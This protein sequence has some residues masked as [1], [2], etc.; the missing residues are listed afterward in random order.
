MSQTVTPPAPALAPGADTG[1]SS[2]D[3]I[4]D[5]NAPTFVGVAAPNA[6]INLYDTDGSLIGT[7]TA[8]T[9]GLYSIIPTMTYT[10]PPQT[11]NGTATNFTAAATLDDGVHR[12]TV[13]AAAPGGSV[14]LAS[15]P[16]V[17]TIDSQPPDAP[18]APVLIAA[19]DT[20]TS[21]LDGITSATT[22]TLTGMSEPGAAVQLSDGMTVLGGTVAAADGSYSIT[23][24]TLDAGD[25]SFTVIATDVAGNASK[26]SGATAVTIDTT[27]PPAPAAPSLT[28]GSDTGVLRTDG[29]TSDTTPVVTGTAEAGATVR[30]LDQGGTLLGQGVA[31]SDGS[32]AIASTPLLAGAHALT[33]TATDPAG[34]AGAASTALNI[35]IDTT[36]GTAT[37]IPVPAAASAGSATF[38]V[39][40]NQPIADTAGIKPDDFSLVTTGT[41]FG[42]VQTV[43]GAGQDFTVVVNGLGGA[44]AIGLAF[45][46]QLGITTVAGNPVALTQSDLHAVSG[47]TA[48]TTVAVS[49]SPTD[50]AGTGENPS[51]SATGRG[52]AFDSTDTTLVPGAAT[53]GFDNI[54]VK[55]LQTG[56]ISI[57]STA[58]DGA[59]DGDSF[60]A[61]LSQNDKVI[62][63][64]S[65]ATNLI[66]DGTT[67][68]QTNI[69]VARLQLADPTSGLSFT[70]V[71]GSLQ[72]VSRGNGESGGETPSPID[73]GPTDHPVLSADGSVVAFT[74]AA[75]LVAGVTAGTDNVYAYN[76]KTGVLTLIST[77]SDGSGGDDESFVTS[78]SGDGSKV[79]F[80]SFADNLS[81]VPPVDADGNEDFRRGYVADTVSGALTVID[82][83]GGFGNLVHDTFYETYDL[84]LSASGT[85]VAY[86]VGNPATVSGIETLEETLAT[87]AVTQVTTPIV[88]NGTGEDDGQVTLSAGGTLAL[89]DENEDGLISSVPYS[90][91]LLTAVGK[92]SPPTLIGTGFQPVLTETGNAAVYDVPTSGDLNTLNVEETTFGITAGIDPIGT[93]DEIDAAA[94]RGIAASGGLLVT[95][96]TNAPVGSPVIV[97]M[98]INPDTGEYS[99][100]VNGTVETPGRWSVTVPSADLAV[101]DGSSYAMRVQVATQSGA[102]FLVARLFTID[103]AAPATPGAPR[104]DAGSDTGLAH[105]G[106]ISGIAAPT[107]TGTTEAGATVTLIDQGGTAPGLVLGE[108]TADANGVWAITSAT[109]TDG[110]HALV[111][112]ATDAAGNISAASAPLALTIDTAAPPAPAAPAVS[113]DS[114]AAEPAAGRITKDTAPTLAGE[115]VA[116]ARVTLYDSDGIAV[117][118]TATADQT[119]HYTITSSTLPD[120]PHK[121]T[122][123]QTDPAGLVSAASTPLDLTVDTLPPLSPVIISLGGPRTANAEH[124]TQVDVN[125]TAEPGS[126][127]D[128]HVDMDS[129]VSGTATVDPEGDYTIDGIV[130]A[131]LHKLTVIA[132]DAAGNASQPSAV[133]P[134]T[135]DGP[136]VPPLG[137]PVGSTVLVGNVSDDEIFGATV[138]EDAN[139]NGVLDPGEVAALTGVTGQYTL[140]G[141]SGPLIATGGKDI[142]SG[143]TL[144]G[145]LTAPAGSAAITPFTTLLDAYIAAGGTTDQGGNDL[146]LEFLG[147]SQ[148]TDVTTLD[149]AA[150]AKAAGAAPETAGSTF[151]AE[152][153]SAGI[154]NAA[155]QIAA[156]IAGAGG[157]AKAAFADVFD[158]YARRLIAETGASL[159]DPA[160]ISALLYAAAAE[161]LPGVTLNAAAVQAATAIIA[162]GETTI[163]DAEQTADGEAGGAVDAG[164]LNVQLEVTVAAGI[165][166][167]AIDA[168]ETEEQSAAATALTQLARDPGLAAAAQAQFTGASLSASL[169]RLTALYDTAIQLAPGDDTGPSAFDHVTT[170]DTPTFIGTT[171][172]GATVT[173]VYNS[174]ALGITGLSPTQVLGT[175]VA[176]S[177]GRFAVTSS[178]L[179]TNT[180]LGTDRFGLEAV[181]SGVNGSLAPVSGS[182][183]PVTPLE[184]YIE[185]EVGPSDLQFS[186]ITSVTDAPGPGSDATHQRVFVNVVVQNI[187]STINVYVDGGTTPVGTA[188]GS[189]SD[190]NGNL[191]IETTPLAL[192]SHLFTITDTLQ[193]GTA[194][195]GDNSRTFVVTADPMSG[196]VAYGNGAIAGAT[197]E[198]SVPVQP[199]AVGAT[200]TGTGQA[201]GYTFPS[202]AKAELR[203]GWDTVTDLQLG[204]NYPPDNDPAGPFVQLDAPAGAS[205]VTALTT[206][207]ADIT[208]RGLNSGL[209]SESLAQA[210]AAIL[211]GLGLSPDLDPLSLNPLAE[212]QAGDT[213]PFLAEARLLDTQAL[214]F[215]A[216]GLDILP[217]LAIDIFNNG[218]LDLDDPAALLAILT[219]VPAHVA[220]PLAQTLATLVAASNADL[221]ARAA[222][223]SGTAALI[224]GTLAAE[225]VAQ[226][227]EGRAIFDAQFA[228]APATA[229]QSVT[230]AYTGAALQALVA[231]KLGQSAQVAAFA[232]TAGTT[233]SAPV[234]HY[235]LQFTQPVSGIG[236][237]AFHLVEGSGLADAF[238]SSV[239]PVLG[240]GGASYDVAVST[241]IGQGTLS[242]GFTGS[243]VLDAGGKPLTSG[244]FEPGQTEAAPFDFA[245]AQGLAAGDFNGDGKLDLVE[246]SNNQPGDGLTVFL[247]NGDGT[248][249]ATGQI[250]LAAQLA[251]AVPAVGD[252]NGDGKLDIVT[253]VAGENDVAVLLGDGDGTFQ[254]PVRTATGNDP[255]ALA[256]G[257]LDGDG[258]ADVV[259]LNGDGTISVLLGQG[260][261]TFLAAPSLASGAFRPAQGFFGSI[262]LADLNGDG[263][264]D[265]VA[266][267]SVNNVVDIFLGNGDG[268]FAPEMSVAT[269]RGPTGIAV[270]DINGDGIPDIVTADYFNDQVSVLLGNGDGTFQADR[271]FTPPTSEPA[272]VNGGQQ[273]PLGIAIADVNND[274]KADLIINGLGSTLVLTGDGTGNFQLADEDDSPEQET[275][276][277]Q[278]LAVGDFNGDGRT[279]FATPGITGVNDY[280]I[281][282]H[283]NAPQT[284]LNATASPVFI[285]RAALAQ[286]ALTQTAG[287]GTLSQSG[288]SY[289]LD[290]GTLSQG[291]AAQALQFAL[292]NV[293]GELPSDA[294]SGTFQTADAP[295]FT[296]TGD[297]LPGPLSGGQSY[298]GLEITADATTVGAH[299]ETIT[300]AARDQSDTVTTF[301]TVPGTDTEEATTASVDGANVAGELPALTL[302]VTDD[303]VPDTSVALLG[304][305][306]SVTFGNAHA[307]DVRSQTLPIANTAGEGAPDLGV[308]ATASGGASVSGAVAGLAAGETD[309]ADVIVGLDTGAAG[310]VTGTVTLVPVSDPSGESPVTLASVPI[311]VSGSVYRLAAPS[312][313]VPAPQIVHVGDPGTVALTVANTGTADGYTENLLASLAAATGGLTVNTATTGEIGAGAPDTASLSL[314]V[315]TAAAA[316]VSGTATVNLVSDGGTGP[317]SLDGLGQTILGTQ[318]VP[319]SVTVDNYAAPVFEDVPE[320]GSPVLVNGGT[321]DLGSVPQG[322]PALTV[323]LGVLNDAAGPADQLSGSLQASGSDA[324]TN[325]GLA[326]FAGIDA[327]QADIA[328]AITL[329]TAAPGTFTET[330]TLTPSGSNASGYAAA[331]PD[332]TLTITGTV[333]TSASSVSPAVADILTSG[334]INFGAV[335]LN[336]PMDIAVQ[337]SN[338]AISG[339]ASLDASVSSTTGD[340]TATGSF[341]GLAPGATD[342]THITGGIDT[343][344]V[345]SQTGTVALAFISDAGTLGVTTLPSQ[346]IAL[347]GT[348]YR[349]AAA[350]LSPVDAIVHVG[351]P[352]VANVSVSNSDP[353][354]GYSESLIAMLLSATGDIGISAAGPGGEIAA[355]QTNATALA[356][357]FSTALAGMVTG[358]ATVGL[359]SDGGTG[360]GSIDGLGQTVLNPGTVAVDIAVD[361]YAEATL[362]SNGDL[363]SAGDDTYTLNLGTANEGASAL[364]SDLIVGNGATGTADYLDG[365]FAIAGGG[366]FGN[367]LASFSQLGAGQTLDAGAVTLA[368]DHA[369]VFSETVTLSPTDANA[370]NYSL[371]EG[372]RTI[373]VTGTIVA[374]P[375]V[376]P[377]GTAQGDVH[378]VTFDGLRYDFQATGDYELA[379]SAVSGDTFQIQIET[380]AASAIAAVSVTTEAAAQVGS[381][382]VTF[383]LNQDGFVWVDGA[384]DTALSAANPIQDFGGGQ[385]QEITP[386]EFQLT[387]PTGEA[388]TIDDDGTSI[389]S[390][391]SL[392]ASDGPGS[393][394][395]LLGSDSGQASDFQLPDG[396]V[397]K[398]PVSDSELLGTFATAW[399]ANSLLGN[400]PM[401]FIYGDGAGQTV[402]QATAAGQVLSGA[403]GA[404]VLSDADGLGVTFQGTLAQL[405]GE[406]IAGFSAK[407]V[408]DITGLNAAA[409]AVSYAAGVLQVSDGSQ[410]GTIPLTGQIAGGRFTATPDTHGGALIALS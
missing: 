241:G 193:G 1:L 375:V 76:L 355:G 9:T 200:T 220:Q 80:D 372:P 12:I 373:T 310:A 298:D 206:L 395:G 268:T 255:Q 169:Q 112:T 55:D 144:P 199:T 366:G 21:A 170:D 168:I 299:T 124:T 202:A 83:F 54:Y 319:V 323:N 107:L 191:E 405:V 10:N 239:T 97:V 67:P 35:L 61:S 263:K 408:I 114:V 143:L 300:F 363:A 406:A 91:L 333:T 109:L 205:V 279:D 352:G 325:N 336:A 307:G 146:F 245:P 209:G 111:V 30:L 130:A 327:G 216:A 5:L 177:S 133:I 223:A 33:V 57:I 65:S 290:L 328:P 86:S 166:V 52:V 173:L 309:S 31:G 297:T 272:G 58:D 404:N 213:A 275:T 106:S 171:T 324:F 26:P 271:P 129:I 183:V 45:A 314:L 85:K 172:P 320:I 99:P 293:L 118:G 410:S 123:T 391:V 260:D 317:G 261:G 277:S 138:F 269:A 163:I 211:D 110:A 253:S 59:P 257:D 14:S 345:G 2:T 322:V 117:L 19:S 62:A 354:D 69:Y 188:N 201:G 289:M 165:F 409:A 164:G 176:D 214:V 337:I 126:T 195:P 131:G 397:L 233:S 84:Q 338:A 92:L 121:L 229:L 56:G 286:P 95:G 242:L 219:S 103:T 221:D 116:G 234:I 187:G 157:D 278:A 218:S 145:D 37:S 81:A 96:V 36:P 155:V 71:P 44:G 378:M 23:T 332:E 128:L 228:D 374:G 32:Y 192:G 329:S 284:V 90:S 243:G 392:P 156:V 178:A 369:G 186:D 340:A 318:I 238:I 365:S 380:A 371:A 42:D 364:S 311:A 105:D 47:T 113:S 226:D 122:V 348:V 39:H 127:V 82:G 13:T 34:N 250:T 231:A 386:E 394:R 321:L 154:I 384:P 403:P 296:V 75:A 280:G 288:N 356:L 66:E 15:A 72:L 217:L 248:F 108:A 227:G 140:I 258:R 136:S 98:L 43:N 197:L 134:V 101:A 27:P 334:P 48:D 393:V 151:N 398:T 331:L 267:D 407:D 383:G 382:V 252:F 185:T 225:E 358:T 22:I 351:D 377:T 283:L 93:A 274:G 203:G 194:V 254:A 349:E 184:F 330:I 396:T 402:L 70:V 273:E 347:S 237:G 304:V 181:V 339:S 246:A 104:L 276:S 361:N 60:N 8:G 153:L 282:V 305:P 189:D 235:T 167:R 3:K 359:T 137:T 266:T 210:E 17:V 316:V 147:L 135:V 63:F 20:G 344:A 64:A 251:G 236:A 77:G 51:P 353:A 224:T 399:Q 125:G 335:H 212:A 149:P 182:A 6:T 281:D 152:A 390:A 370:D 389:G 161:A 4:T 28:P 88:V 150:A 294:L 385:L 139:G 50:P 179:P 240:S 379:R 190:G 341:T 24:G 89:Y 222:A 308:T 25:H 313:T 11:A 400:P 342:T 74:S 303:V 29:V 16:L 262:A 285:N 132:T 159:T 367:Y 215:D 287:P 291:E 46:A 73:F 376:A 230:Q 256:V 115:A 326:S 100:A 346:T 204:G 174:N 368:T 381:D 360:G 362:A 78:I 343:A 79:A 387:W 388:L 244:L 141:G 208:G 350:A 292:T 357:S 198:P 162:A 249:T 40:F 68:G 94:A 259:T 175:T 264:L 207:I 102:S 18:A 265:V 180:L 49:V 53:G 41:A 312:V 306:A 315:S 247:N 302:V 295:G 301:T 401:Q 196:G 232:A 120:G 160:N 158:V 119:G 270:G 142:G 7:G 87:G 148:L 38:K